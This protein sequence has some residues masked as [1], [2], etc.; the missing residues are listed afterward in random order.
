M[1]CVSLHIYRT[2]ASVDVTR[3]RFIVVVV[4]PAHSPSPSKPLPVVFDVAGAKSWPPDRARAHF[5]VHWTHTHTH[6]NTCATEPLVRTH[7]HLQQK[8]LPMLFCPV[9]CQSSA[10]EHEPLIH[11]MF[12]L[13]CLAHKYLCRRPSSECC[14]LPSR[15][16]HFAYQRVVF[17]V[18]FSLV[19][20][21]LWTIDRQKCV[22]NLTKNESK[23]I[24]SR[25][26]LISI[27]NWSGPI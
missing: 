3:E 8:K 11:G 12:V 25:M 26:W 10:A 21:P 27:L 24:K 17:H 5:A 18:L 23:R 4:R 1:A 19:A 15:L 7:T 2:P 22:R 14:W 13:V 20:I 6:T 9:C 16:C